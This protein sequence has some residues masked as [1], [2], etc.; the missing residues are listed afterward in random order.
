MTFGLDTTDT[1][2]SAVRTRGVENIRPILEVFKK[3]GHVEIDTARAYGNGDTEKALA[4]QNMKG[5]AIAT[6][7]WPNKTHAHGEH[8]KA[9]FY[10]SLKSLKT[11]KVDIFYL[12]APDYSTPFEETIRLVDELYREGRFER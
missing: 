12:H 10:E 1:T 7:V 9:T 4:L 6:K 8:L 3:H 5:L 11:E 2:T